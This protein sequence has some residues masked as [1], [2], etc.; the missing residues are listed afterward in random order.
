MEINETIIKYDPSL[1]EFEG[2]IPTKVR[3]FLKEGC[4]Q[5][6]S[7]FRFRC[8]PIKGYNKNTYNMTYEDGR[9][10]CNCQAFV[11]AKKE[12]SHIKALKLGLIQKRL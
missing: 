6:V 7:E 2:G 9:F 11:K 3:K 8:L 5:R 10:T 1:K 4:I 12:C